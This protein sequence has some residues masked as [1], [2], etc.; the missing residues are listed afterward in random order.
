MEMEL[1][2]YDAKVRAV[3]MFGPA[4]PAM[5][6]RPAEFYQATIDPDMVSPNGKLIRFG[7]YIGDEIIGWQ[8]VDAMTVVEVLGRCDQTLT[9]EGYTEKP[10]ATVTL[11]T[12]K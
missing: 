8:A 2:T 11:R 3:L 10:G 9:V 1:K 12:V 4:T 6:N 5:G 7:Y